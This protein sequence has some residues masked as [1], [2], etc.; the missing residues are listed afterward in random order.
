MTTL[1]LST[2]KPIP[3]FDCVA[4][5]REIQAA[6]YEETKDM[7]SE[8][9]LE[10]IRKESKAFREEQRRYRAERAALAADLN[11]FPPPLSGK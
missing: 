1:D 10:Y 7:T 5:K 4:M 9:Y 8:E 6:I 11:I 3:G 2:I